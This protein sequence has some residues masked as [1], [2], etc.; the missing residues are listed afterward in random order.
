MRAEPG[1]FDVI[2]EQ[3]RVLR[4]FVVF[5][6]EKLFLEIEAG[7]PGKVT[8]DFQ[9]LTLAMSIHVAGEHPLAGNGIMRATCG[10]NM[11]I[12]RPPAEFCGID[13]PLEFEVDGVMGLV[14]L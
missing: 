14:D 2:M 9:I 3:V 13:P 11:M 8:A 12:A 7:P 5:G 10:V 1:D 6:S 4:D